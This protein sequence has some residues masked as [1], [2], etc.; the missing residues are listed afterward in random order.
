M[1]KNSLHLNSPEAG[2]IRWT[3][4]QLGKN[5]HK[6]EDIRKMAYTKWLRCS[7]SYFSKLVRNPAYCGLIPV[8]LNSQEQ[9]MV[10]GVH[11][12][13]I[14]EALFF[15]VQKII[16][17]KRKT[18]SKTDKLKA[19]FFLRGH[20]ICPL[21]G[22]KLCGSFSQGSTKKH[23]YYHC[24]GRCKTRINAVRLNDSYQRKLQQLELAKDSMNYS[25]TF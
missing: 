19:M 18:T 5:I 22:R 23:P 21:C 25:I 12:P 4:L 9:Q 8:T 3:F 15:E 14:S 6:I 20:L 2:I 16:N 7:R 1:A 11:D 10:K 24:R 17:T 13:L